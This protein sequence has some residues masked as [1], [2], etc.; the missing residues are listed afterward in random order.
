METNYTLP[1]GHEFI[2]TFVDDFLIADRYGI[3]A[4]KD[5]FKRA[6]DA[7]HTDPVY[8]A[9]LVV[10]LNHAIWRYYKTRPDFAEIY[11]NI[12][13]E[14]HNKALSQFK[15]KDFQTYYDIVD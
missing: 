1:N 10:T 6:W 13:K 9:E 7:W 3:P 12:W 4:I 14:A 2:S 8:C 11:K 5:T 15:G